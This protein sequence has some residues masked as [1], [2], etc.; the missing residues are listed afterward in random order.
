MKQNVRAFKDRFVVQVEIKNTYETSQLSEMSVY[1]ENWNPVKPIYISH[2]SARL[3]SD[4][5]LI[6]TAVVPMGD[7]PYKIYHICHA[8][9]PI[10]GGV[11]ATYKGEVCGK[12]TAVKLQG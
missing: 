5:K 10:R 3:G 7:D 4:R 6:V 12:V 2:R 9:H 1:D 8:I 11:A